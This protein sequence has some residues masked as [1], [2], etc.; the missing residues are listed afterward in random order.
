[1]I[2]LKKN[3]LRIE[4]VKQSHTPPYYFHIFNTNA[5][6]PNNR[7]FKNS[8]SIIYSMLYLNG[9]LLSCKKYCELRLVGVDCLSGNEYNYL[10][11]HKKSLKT[12]KEVIMMRKSKKDTHKNDQKKMDKRTN[13]NLQNTTQKT[14]DRAT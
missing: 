14:K 11:F 3:S 13:N 7:L 8:V 2:W 10:V 4:H 5:A 6:V 1:M 9:N 12:P